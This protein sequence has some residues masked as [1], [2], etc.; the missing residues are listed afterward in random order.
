MM[1]AVELSQMRENEGGLT[2]STVFVRVIRVNAFVWKSR[3]RIALRNDIAKNQ[4]L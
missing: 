2:D 4:P 1:F 3:V